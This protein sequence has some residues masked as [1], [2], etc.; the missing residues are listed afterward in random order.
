MPMLRIPCRR[1]RT[2]GATGAL[3]RGLVPH[4]IITRP[5]GRRRPRGLTI[6]LAALAMLAGLGPAHADEHPPVQMASE[7]SQHG[8]TWRFEREHQVGQFVNGDWWVVGPVTIVEVDP[9][10]GPAPEDEVNDLGTNRWGSTGMQD[11]TELRNGSMIIPRAGGGQGY[12]SRGR[13]YRSE[14]TVRF[15]YELDADR[16]LISTISHT[17]MPNRVMHH[18]L[19]W[20]SEQRDQRVLRTAAVITALAEPPPADAFRPTYADTDKRLFRLADVQWD[21]LPRLPAPENTPSWTQYERYFERPWLDHING[22]WLGQW[23]LPTENQPAYYREWSRITGIASLMLMLDVPREQKQPLLIGLVQ[24]AIDARGVADIG[25]QW[26]DQGSGRKWPILMAGV[27]LDDPYFADLPE[28]TVFK[29]DVHTYYGQGWAGQ[30][31]LYQLV[32][33]HGPRQPYEHLPPDQWAEHDGGWGRTAESYRLCCTIKGWVGTALAARLMGGKRAWDHDAFFDNVGRWMNPDDPY[34]DNRG[35][36]PRPETET[37]SFDDFVD[38]MWHAYRAEAPEEP[39]GER[40]RKWSHVDGEFQWIP[41][42]R[43]TEADGG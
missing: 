17:T 42:E 1:R 33:H 18:E 34:A 11:N 20:P 35:E 6:V 27:L 16:S 38:T 10:P 39:R 37:T 23:L 12:D 43:P 19:M 36:H 4:R 32:Q 13:S 7:V 14:L 22:S 24:Y 41:N 21:R 8:I 29:E 3:H 30:T 40:H 25:G 15:P 28:S 9:A 26:I 5:G 31:A 2:I